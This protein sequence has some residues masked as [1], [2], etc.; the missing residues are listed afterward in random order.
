MCT[1]VVDALI[2]W[3]APSLEGSVDPLLAGLAACDSS[4]REI[5]M[6]NH[7]EEPFRLS[8]DQRAAYGQMYNVDAL[9]ELLGMLPDEDR[10]SL[11]N[12]GAGGGPGSIMGMPVGSSDPELHAIIER[13]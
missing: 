5:I 4:E 11:L 12:S 10:E 6:P 3:E 9:E 7:A 2:S 1:G 8:P 13:V